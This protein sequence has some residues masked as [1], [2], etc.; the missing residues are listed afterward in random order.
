M[1]ANYLPVFRSVC[2]RS[3][4]SLKVQDVV[5]VM[6]FIMSSDVGKHIRDKEDVSLVEFMY[7]EF[8][9]CGR[10]SYR[11]RLGSLLV[12]ACVQCV[13]SIFRAQLIPIAYLSLKVSN[14]GA[15]TESH[16]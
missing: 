16:S 5:V 13:T 9:A 12:W 2:V 10:W 6:L 3:L 14:V 15:G 1:S 11:R 8:I 4:L 7:L